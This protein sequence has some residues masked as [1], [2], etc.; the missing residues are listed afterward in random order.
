MTNWIKYFLLR[1][2]FMMKVLSATLLFIMMALTFIDV[3]G[4]YLFNSP[5]YGSAEMIQ[6][7]LALTI[8]S[9]LGIVNADDSH[10]VV[11]VF[12]DRIRKFIPNLHGYLIQG[13]SVL[14]MAFISWQLYVFALDSYHL[15]SMTTV[16]EWPLIIV[17]GSVALL[18]IISLICLICGLFIK[19]L[20]NKKDNVE[21]N[22]GDI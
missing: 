19:N 1:V 7:L 3:L 4:R 17:T 2:V 5:I 9:A 21:A 18:S 12:E 15:G 13:F 20:F 10:I 22:T 11:E 8:F 6:F 16:L 14:A